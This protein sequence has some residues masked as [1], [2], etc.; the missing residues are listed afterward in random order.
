MSNLSVRRSSVDWTFGGT[1]PYEP[2]WFETDDGRLHYVDEGSR[3]APAVVLVH[4]N[5]TWGYL[6]RRFIDPLVDAG[7]RVVVP[8]CLGFGRSAKPPSADLYRIGSH[9]SRMSA[10]LDALDLRNVTIVPQDWGG[11]IALPWAV[12]NPDRVTR[13]YI[14][15]TA[16]HVPPGDVGIPL[17]L[18]L[19]RMRGIGE[20]LVKGLRLFHHGFLFRVGVV[21]RD[22]LTPEVKRAYLDP[23]PSWSSRTGVLVFPREI[24]A[25]PGGPWD[26]FA[27]DMEAGLEAHFQDRPVRIM[28]AMKDPGFA[29]EWI[30]QMWLRTLPHA[31]VARLNDAGHYLQEDAHEIIVPDLLRFLDSTDPG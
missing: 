31:D 14:L 1:W 11:P 30:D 13:L 4:G 26:E 23:H 22:R 5:P 2:R 18:R 25:G 17:P 10:L 29:P 8:D 28:W 20:L 27:R 7:Y 6:Y 3:D 21:H 12:A 15:N 24:P 9:V 19:F 16:V